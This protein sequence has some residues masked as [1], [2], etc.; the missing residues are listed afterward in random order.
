MDVMS[1]NWYGT[2]KTVTYILVG[3]SLMDSWIPR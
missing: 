3:M 1:E 2:S